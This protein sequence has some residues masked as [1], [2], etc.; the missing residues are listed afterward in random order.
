MSDYKPLIPYEE[1]HRQIRK[2]WDNLCP[3][4]PTPREEILI[5]MMC[6]L[7]GSNSAAMQAYVDIKIQEIKNEPR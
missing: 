4:G 3:D 1:M 2:S 5:S 6:M 7:V